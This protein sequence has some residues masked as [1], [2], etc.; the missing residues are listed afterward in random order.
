VIP[1]SDNIIK[2]FANVELYNIY[3]VLQQDCLGYITI[4]DH[5]DEQLSTK[6][7]KDLDL[8]ERKKIAFGVKEGYVYLEKTGI[9]QGF[10]CLIS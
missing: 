4:M 7:R 10:T 1:Y 3:D 5:C 9:S 8:E 2:H 6:L